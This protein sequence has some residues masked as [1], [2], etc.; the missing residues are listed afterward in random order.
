[1]PLL[2][3]SD[4]VLALAPDAQISGAARGLASPQKWRTLGLNDEAAWGECAGSGQ[5]PYQVLAQV[6]G[7]AFHCSCPSRKRPCKHAL[8]LL[9]LIAKHAPPS[10]A[11]MP[12]WAAERLAAFK[13]RPRAADAPETPRS[14][15]K[16]TATQ[17]SARRET[18]VAAG[19]ESLSLWLAD[20]VRR[21]LA[22]AQTQPPRFWEG[23][24]ARLVDAQAP[25]AAR[26]VRALGG[27]PA[28]GPAWP[29]RL[30]AGL[31]QLHL[32]VEGYA[33][34]ESLPADLQ[35]DVRAKL[36]FTLQ[37]EA[38]LKEAGVRDRWQVLGWR[39]EEEDRLRA[40]R[41]WLWGERSQ[42]PALVLSYAAPGQALDTRLVPGT[43]LEAELVFFPSAFP[44]RALL[45]PAGAAEALGRLP[46]Q[47]G[48]AGA[49]A[50]YG[51]ALARSP[52]IENFP[53]AIDAAT[54]VRLNGAWWV[55]DAA[56][57]G[58]PLAT[59]FTAAWSLLALSGGTTVPMFGEWDGESFWPLSVWAEG[60]LVMLDG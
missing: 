56:G 31:G 48:I 24:A 27:L 44:L 28:S 13:R 39:V 1:M 21:G 10:T 38:L 40:R 42:R 4:Q 51:G 16:T 23:M 26:L 14:R 15:N 41:V 22:A 12:E 34:L 30:T 54:P 17:T 60:R 57:D 59:D 11:E 45:K 58:W 9:L 29:E 20:L 18:R 2:P 36:G 52:W 7:L 33:R 53:A 8:A 3:T 37:H 25:G 35:A 47:T 19:M 49:A 43:A 5:Q 6:A 32:L 46:S 50:A 55:R